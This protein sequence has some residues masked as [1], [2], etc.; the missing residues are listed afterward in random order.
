MR[1]TTYLNK[2]INKLTMLK[3]IKTNLNET[4]AN[5][6]ATGRL[7][8]ISIFFFIKGKKEKRRKKSH[9]CFIFVRTD[10][11]HQIRVFGD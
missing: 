4:M 9:D 11:K 2:Q 1:V 7:T 3:T 10:R 6:G 8:E 5:A